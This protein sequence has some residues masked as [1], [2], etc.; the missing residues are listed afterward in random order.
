MI[1]PF[2]PTTAKIKD[3]PLNQQKYYTL[4]LNVVVTAA[5]LQQTLE[6]LTTF[7]YDSPVQIFLYSCSA[8]SDQSSV[9]AFL[10]HV[11]DRRSN[12]TNIPLVHET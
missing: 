1:C 10:E 11:T 2:P 7:S 4:V 6:R 5:L 3:N 12:C 9:Q 8:I